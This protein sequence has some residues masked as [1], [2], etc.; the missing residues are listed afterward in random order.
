MLA[1]TAGAEAADL[2]ETTVLDS[3]VSA[4][5]ADNVRGGPRSIGWSKPSAVRNLV[6]LNKAGGFSNATHLV[7]AGA[8]VLSNIEVFV[9]HYT[10]YPSA[11]TQLFHN[12][13]FNETLIGID[14]TDFCTALASQANNVGFRLW[15]GTGA[16]KLLKVY[17]SAGLEFT[18]AT[19]PVFSKVPVWAPAEMHGQHAYKLHAKARITLQNVSREMLADYYAMPKDDPI[20]LYDDTG[21]STYGNR[22]PEKLWH[23]I[24]QAENVQ[25]QFDDLYAISLDLGILKHGSGGW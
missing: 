21:G 23:C 1:N 4:P 15:V 12:G 8:D 3:E 7:I 16:L 13:N 10:S 14:G 22:I 9:S 5:T 11:E 18:K 17:F 24:I 2:R 20:F 6:Y 19:Q 25:Q